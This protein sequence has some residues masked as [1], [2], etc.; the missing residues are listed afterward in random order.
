VKKLF[1]KVL[2]Q[3]KLSKRYL[4]KDIIAGITVALILIPQSLAY[5]QLAGLP[6]QIGLYASLLPPIVAVVFGSSQ[7]MSTGPV[8]IR[9]LMTAAALTP[10]AVVGGSDYIIYA[11]ILTFIL[12]VILLTLGLFKLG[13]FVNFLSHPVV[14]GFTNAAVIIIATTQLANFFGVASVSYPYHYQTVIAVAKNALTNTHLPTLALGI[15]SLIA[16]VIF[17]KVS[18]RIPG[19]LIIIIVSS[20]TVFITGYSGRLVGEIPSGLPV[21]RIPPLNTAII[22]QLFITAT[23]MALVGFT[24]AISVAQAMAI[25]TKER[26]DPNKELIG[27][28]LANVVSALSSGYAVSGSFSRTS[29]NYQSGAKTWF[30]SVVSSFVVLLTLLIFTKMLFFIPTVT[31]AAVIILAVSSL[32]DFSKIKFIW[33]T[34]RYDA[35]AAVLTFLGTL[36][37]APRIEIGVLIGVVFSMSHFVF[38]STHPRVSFLSRYK[39]DQFHDSNAF[40]LNRCAN[41]AVVRLDAPLFFANASY[42]ENII[43][44][45]LSDNPKLTYILIDASGVNEID[46]TG[47]EMLRNLVE[48]LRGAKKELYFSEVRRPVAE[49]LKKSGLWEDVGDNNFF[50]TTKIAVKYLLKHLAKEHKHTDF[51][52]CPLSRYIENGKGGLEIERH[53]REKIADVYNRLFLK[54]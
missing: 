31:L 9:S 7:L 53:Y 49:M 30:S 46:A 47:E 29:V 32:V 3:K 45:D 22:G 8:A 39:D 44:K 1:K 17:K 26:L 21:L 4:N 5:A 2:S 36:Y 27:Q 28:G 41:I 24:E 14:Y 16:M 51:D 50:P 40:H 6:P 34:N 54:S 10:I 37:F 42:F 23:T 19:T 35:A 18:P 13:E 33:A 25:K 12:G 52:K 43:I 48:E 11:L 20:L 15:S 38:Q